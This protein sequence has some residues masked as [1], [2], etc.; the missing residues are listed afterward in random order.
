MHSSSVFRS[1]VL[2]LRAFVLLGA[3]YDEPFGFAEAA[4]AQFGAEALDDVGR[5]SGKDVSSKLV[6]CGTARV[7]L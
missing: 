4:N 1:S 5:G 2:A 6:N 7:S 3:A